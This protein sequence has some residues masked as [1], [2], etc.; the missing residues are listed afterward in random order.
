MALLRF[1]HPYGG[2]S[3]PPHWCNPSPATFQYRTQS[4]VSGVGLPK[5]CL[6]FQRPLTALPIQPESWQWLLPYGRHWSQSEWLGKLLSG[7]LHQGLDQSKLQPHGCGQ[8]HPRKIRLERHAHHEKLGKSPPHLL[9]HGISPAESRCHCAQ[10]GYLP[11]RS[12]IYHE[13]SPDL[14]ADSRRYPRTP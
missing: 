11:S 2:N 14:D 6:L 4:V 13:K 1:V 12:A 10:T 8:S 5:A 9:E 3:S 7:P